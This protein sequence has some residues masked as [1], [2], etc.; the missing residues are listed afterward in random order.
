MTKGRKI[1]RKK[2]IDCI[3][4]SGGL[5]QRVAT[6]AGYAWGTVNEFIKADPELSAMMTYEE[7]RVN[8]VAENTI[9]VKIYAGDEASAKWWLSR[10]RRGKFGDVLD[11]TSGGQALSFKVVYDDKEST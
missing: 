1:S 5:I 3:P 8:D 11:I 6:K 4:D 7:E 9:M 2:V 10:R